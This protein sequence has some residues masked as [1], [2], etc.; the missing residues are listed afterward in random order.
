MLTIGWSIFKI[1]VDCWKISLLG[2]GRAKKNFVLSL[3]D[4]IVT[5]YQ[6]LSQSAQKSGHTDR[7]S[8]ALRDRINRAWHK[9]KFLFW[10]S[11]TGG[12]GHQYLAKCEESHKLY[13]IMIV[14]FIWAGKKYNSL[15]WWFNFQVWN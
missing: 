10:Q 4:L 5:A 13:Q 12:Q 6:F 2:W 7:H 1:I 9:Q 8:I 14:K 3:V 11:A 15:V